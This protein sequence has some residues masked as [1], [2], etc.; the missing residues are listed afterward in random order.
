MSE[1][2]EWDYD[3]CSENVLEKY[4]RYMNPRV[5]QICRAIGIERER[6]M[7]KRWT[8]AFLAL[9]LGIILYEWTSATYQATQA[10]ANDIQNLYSSPS[11]DHL[12]EIYTWLR[13]HCFSSM[14]HN[15]VRYW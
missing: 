7:K 10:S 5:V 6:P 9:A 15:R 4:F 11:H 8:A 3:S 2:V 12:W 14:I 13:G 1:I